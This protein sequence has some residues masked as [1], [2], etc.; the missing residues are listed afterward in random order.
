LSIVI[1]IIEAIKM[2]K[3]APRTSFGRFTITDEMLSKMERMVVLHEV[4]Y[5]VAVFLRVVWYR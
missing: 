3:S 4:P 5:T 1:P 2:R